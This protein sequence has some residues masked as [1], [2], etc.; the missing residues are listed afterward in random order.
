[1]PVAEPA[2]SARAAANNILRCI[3]L[4]LSKGFEAALLKR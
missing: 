2:I 1:M 4:S 3:E